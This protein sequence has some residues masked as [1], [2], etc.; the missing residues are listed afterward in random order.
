M[1]LGDRVVTDDDGA[2]TVTGSAVDADGVRQPR[3]VPP[4]T[5]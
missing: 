5:C 2:G 4:G 1:D 3:I